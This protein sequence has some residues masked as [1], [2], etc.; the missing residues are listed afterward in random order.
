[1][2]QTHIPVNALSVAFHGPS[3]LI[4]QAVLM[5]G[6][7]KRTIYYWIRDGRLQ[8]IRT[9]C[10]SQRILLSSIDRL[11]GQAAPSGAAADPARADR[12]SS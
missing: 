7:S 11:V 2:E 5:L 3:V 6:V 12:L 9:R 1:V 8:T 4:D 10:G